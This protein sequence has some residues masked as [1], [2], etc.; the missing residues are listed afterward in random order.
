MTISHQKPIWIALSEMYLDTELEGK[1]FASIAAKIKE[2][3]FS[4]KEV[5]R[6]NKEEVFPVLFTNLLSVAGV[7]TGFQEEWLINAISQKLKKRTRFNRLLNNI[8][9]IGM[10]WMFMDYWRKIKV[11]YHK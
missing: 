2:S 6:I 5:K 9:Y 1:D 7:W 4:F 10:K 11:E 3:P 8:P